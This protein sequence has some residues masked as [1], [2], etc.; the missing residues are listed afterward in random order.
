MRFLV[1][2]HETARIAFGHSP[3]GLL[4]L[5]GSEHSGAWTDASEESEAWTNKTQEAETWTVVGN[6]S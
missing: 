1:L 6:D 3:N 4:V 2:T 5:R